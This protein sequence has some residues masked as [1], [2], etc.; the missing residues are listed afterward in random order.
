M[1]SDLDKAA[2]LIPGKLRLNLP[3]SYAETGG[4]KVARNALEPV[5]FQVWI[6]WAKQRGMGMDF[7][8]TYFGRPKADDGFT[9]S[10][11][12]SDIRRFWIEHGVACRR[13]GAAMG[14]ALGT[15]CITNVWVPDGM[16]D[17]P[18]FKPFRGLP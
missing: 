3:A 13:I 6:D 16:K 4:A 5:H 12:D 10:H 7:T 9:L 1:R 11:P 14:A 18:I 2:S 17:L 8:P 15:P